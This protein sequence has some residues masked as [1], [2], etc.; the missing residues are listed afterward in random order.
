MGFKSPNAANSAIAAGL[1]VDAT[2]VAVN[3]T[4]ANPSLGICT[5]GAAIGDYAVISESGKIVDGISSAAISAG[6]VLTCTTA[7]K[8]VTSALAGDYCVGIALTAAT[9]ADE[10]IQVKT[11]FFKF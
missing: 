1:V 4:K 2:G 6:A 11:E 5:I 7:G 3:A 10:V 9:G 8:L